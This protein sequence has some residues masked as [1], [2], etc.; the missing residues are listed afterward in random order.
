MLRVQHLLAY[1]N[2]QLQYLLH[3][4]SRRESMD[5]WSGQKF[6]NFK[7]FEDTSSTG[8]HGYTPSSEW[9]RDMYDNFLEAHQHEINQHM[10]MLSGD[11]CAID[12]SHKVTKHV[13]RVNGEQVFTGLLTVTNSLSEIRICNFVATKSHSQFIDALSRMQE[14]LTL[15]GHKQP[16]IF[17][18]D[19]M[20]DKQLLES[21]FPSLQNDVVPIENYAHLPAFE[22]P[23]DVQVFVKNGVQSINDA[24]STILSDVPEDGSELVVG[25]DSEWNVDVT[26]QG[27]V[28]SS[29]QTAV[30]QIAFKKRVYVLQISDMINS[31]SL[32]NQLE[33]LLSN[34]HIRKA[35]RSVNGDLIAL[36]KAFRRPAGAFCGALDL[37]RLAKER[38]IVTDIS[39]T[40]LA[41]LTALVLQMRLNKNAYLRTNE[42]W[43]NHTLDAAQC[44]YAAKDA[45]VSL[46]VYHEIMK[47]YP[48]PSPLLATTPALTPVL[49]Y[50][51]NMEKIIASGV[52]SQKAHLTAFDGINISHKHALVDVQH[53]HAPGAKLKSH[54][55]QTLKSFGD[56]PFTIACERDQLRTYVPLLPPPPSTMTSI[57][58]RSDRYSDQVSRHDQNQADF[59][60]HEPELD[61]LVSVGDSL[62]EDL[63]GPQLT[64]TSN[65]FSAGN[66]SS[67]EEPKLS[68]AQLADLDFAEKKLGPDMSSK[69]KSDQSKW[70]YETHSRV[71]KTHGIFFI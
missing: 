57:S 49:I 7:P 24:I 62:S 55:K 58:E 67:I 32:P 41:D 45:Y 59:F 31:G 22:I 15:Y 3:V 52:L 14:S 33:L 2:L 26:P 20:N 9:L 46:M 53:V 68:Q 10:S 16:T 21:T 43:E 5:R 56:I 11:I 25:F 19:N 17:Y 54:R 71:L 60:D 27:F 13:A 12:H 66:S 29:G 34:P 65:H 37:A 48:Q 36:Q 64:T 23:D 51:S 4:E 50:A 61:G 8:R 28:R 1:S 18:T 40:A 30:V 44:S 69:L 6:S 42:S 70:D 47:R 38:N 39:S 63:S 35:G